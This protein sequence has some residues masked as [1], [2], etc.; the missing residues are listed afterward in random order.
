MRVSGR[1]PVRRIQTRIL[2]RVFRAVREGTP[3]TL[4]RLAQVGAP[5]EQGNRVRAIPRAVE[6][7]I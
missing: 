1:V 3:P 4:D 6:N 5:F 7:P 2:I